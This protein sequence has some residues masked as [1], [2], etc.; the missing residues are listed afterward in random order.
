MELNVVFWKHQAVKAQ[1]KDASPALQPAGHL[2]AS[3][4]RQGSVH[5]DH[6]ILSGDSPA[7]GVTTLC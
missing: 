2:P 6:P 3:I 7:V 4:N 1:Q 5:S